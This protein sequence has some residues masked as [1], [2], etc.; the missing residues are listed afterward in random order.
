MRWLDSKESF[1][2]LGRRYNIIYEFS[3]PLKYKLLLEQ[4]IKEICATP[5]LL[6]KFAELNFIVKNK[7]NTLSQEIAYVV[8]YD[9][10]PEKPVE[11]LING[12]EFKNQLDKLKEY[13][14]AVL[15]TEIKAV[16]Y[17]EV[18][19]LLHEFRSNAISLN[20]R[21][22]RR[23]NDPNL[24]KEGSDFNW[25][26]F[27]LIGWRAKLRYFINLIHEEGLARFGEN[28]MR[29]LNTFS[30]E[31]EENLY[32]KAKERIEEIMF[33]MNNTLHELGNSDFN[34]D[35]LSQIRNKAPSSIELSKKLKLYSYTIGAYIFFLRK[36]HMK[37]PRMFNVK[38][39]KLIKDYERMEK[40]Q[41]LITLT[42]GKGI[43]DY[44]T[45]ISKWVE[46]LNKK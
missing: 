40:R 37:R 31:N 12:E 24:A 21:S 25:F 7:T 39:F 23:L 9:M 32:Q 13:E 14:E 36:Y 30:P 46:I 34:P 1:E 26:K 28:Y 10:D 15:K 44:N 22:K 16:I 27:D 8:S 11:I 6:D 5:G 35:D 2:I 4:A 29:G 43:F 20:Q 3:L 41:P 38:P 33:L 45:A 19:H 17:H 42:S 18:T